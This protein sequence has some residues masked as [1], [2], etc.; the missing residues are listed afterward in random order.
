MPDVE[1]FFAQVESERLTADDRNILDAALHAYALAAA[2]VLE[3]CE[4]TVNSP[5]PSSTR[6]MR[7]GTRGT[8]HDVVTTP[9]TLT[10]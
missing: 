5:V 10:V 7:N 2:G 6:Y 9:L 3:F 8:P 1:I 4:I